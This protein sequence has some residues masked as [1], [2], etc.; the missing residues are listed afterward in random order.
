[1]ASTLGS[2]LPVVSLR[3]GSPTA[4]AVIVD[5]LLGLS[6]VEG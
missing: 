1:M 2:A 3:A 4:A 6:G 5:D